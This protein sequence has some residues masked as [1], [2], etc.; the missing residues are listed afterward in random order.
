MVL[1]ISG[2]TDTVAFYSDWLMNRFDEVFIDVRNHFNY[3]MVHRIMSPFSY[4]IWFLEHT[5]NGENYE[6]ER[7]SK[8]TS[9]PKYK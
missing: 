7:N 2:R 6:Q 9:K 3:K 8:K 5:N 4:K 1:N